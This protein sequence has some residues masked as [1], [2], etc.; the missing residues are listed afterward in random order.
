[1]MRQST[2]AKINRLNYKLGSMAYGTHSKIAAL[3]VTGVGLG[4]LSYKGI[5]FT[6]K[7]KS[8]RNL[9]HPRQLPLHPSSNKRPTSVGYKVAKIRGARPFP[10]TRIVPRIG[11]TNYPLFGYKK[12][13]A[14]VHSLSRKGL[15]TVPNLGNRYRRN[16]TRHEYT[17]IRSGLSKQA[18]ASYMHRFS[19]PVRKEFHAGRAQLHSVSFRRSYIKPLS[20]VTGKGAYHG[21]GHHNV[22]V[23]RGQHGHFAGSY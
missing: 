8:N 18:N 13:G 7:A 5:K 17:S 16:L 10:G 9:I 4:Y 12:H 19:F 20:K 22:N 15:S 1:M 2:W 3:G 11:A 21:H 6:S 14:F 23:R